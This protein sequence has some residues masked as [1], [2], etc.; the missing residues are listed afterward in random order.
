MSVR[1]SIVCAL[2]RVWRICVRAHLI[3]RD[4]LHVRTNHV[5]RVHGYVVTNLEL[6]FPVLVREFGPILTIRYV[7]VGGVVIA[8]LLWGGVF[9]HPLLGRHD[10]TESHLECFALL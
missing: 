6:T 3:D 10:V 2:A 8:R 9:L 4:D 1:E 5:R 7:L